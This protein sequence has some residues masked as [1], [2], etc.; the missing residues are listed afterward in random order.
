MITVAGSSYPPVGFYFSV[1][2]G[3]FISDTTF[4]E[5]SGLNVVLGTE[6]IKEGGEN[7]FIY[8]LPTPPKYSNLILKRGMVTGSALI[9][10]ARLAVENFT[11]MPQTV[12]IQLL[13]S[14]ADLPLA[15][16]N[17]A[18]AYPLSLKVSDFKAQDSNIV[19]ETLELAF[20]T[21]Q[22]LL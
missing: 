4:Q 17:V 6:D 13:S 14:N 16:W 19:I 22:R 21:L 12:I 2:V 3:I 10:W 5:V 18:N 9:D 11:F 8:R 1:T 15:A 7:Q 20:T